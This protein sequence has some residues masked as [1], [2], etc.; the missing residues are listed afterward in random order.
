M[1]EFSISRKI[2]FFQAFGH[3][4]YLK[5][6]IKKVHEGEKL[7]CHLCKMEFKFKLSLEN[8]IKRIHEQS[9]EHKCEMCGMSFGCET[10]LKVYHKCKGPKNDEN[11]G[12]NI[13]KFSI[14]RIF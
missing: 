1:N 13:G 6:H 10:T 5:M 11:S 9:E 8:H 4:T 12:E 3:Q 14:S 7:P 2:F